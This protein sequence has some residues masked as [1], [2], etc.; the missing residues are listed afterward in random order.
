MKNKLT[1]LAILAFAAL[2]LASCSKYPGFKKTKNGL[3]YKFIVENKDTAK[4][5]INDV[6]EMYLSYKGVSKGKDTVLMD[7][8]QKFTLM[9]MKSFFKGDIYEGLGMMSKGDSAIFIMPADSFF[10]KIV[11]APKLPEFIDSASMLTFNVKMLDFY[12]Q[13]EMQRR[14][15]EKNAQLEKEENEKLQ[16][17]LTENNITQQPTESGLIYIEIKKGNGPKAVNGKTV[18]VH[19]TGTL[20]DGTKFDSSFDHPDKKPLEFKIGEGRIIKGFEEGISMMSKGGKAKLIIP[21]KL[22]YGSRPA[23]PTI[24]AFATL[25]FEVELVDVK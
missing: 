25:V 20:L 23:G 17:Y 11:H 24:P 8:K 2:M 15:E 14:E 18:S 9:M 16:K 13:E 6:M 22:A 3:Y 10:K 5:H 21:S 7:G 4:P 19:Y 12:S 1:T